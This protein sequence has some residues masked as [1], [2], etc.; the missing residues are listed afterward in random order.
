MFSGSINLFVNA[1]TTKP[2]VDSSYRNFEL[3]LIFSLPFL[4]F[5]DA[6]IFLRIQAVTDNLFHIVLND[7]FR[8]DFDALFKSK[9]LPSTCRLSNLFANCAGNEIVVAGSMP[10]QVLTGSCWRLSDCDLYT[11]PTHL[12]LARENLKRMGFTEVNH[13]DSSNTILVCM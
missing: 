9:G 8:R 2:E 6:C 4:N 3:I 10:L 12:Q 7:I 13:T 5:N 11:T 1:R